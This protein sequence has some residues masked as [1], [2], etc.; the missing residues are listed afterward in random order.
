[1]ELAGGAELQ[2]QR[3]KGKQQ[4][5]CNKDREYWL[6][7]EYG[8]FHLVGWNSGHCK[9]TNTIS[10][11]RLPQQ[12]GEPNTNLTSAC[13]LAQRRLGHAFPPRPADT[14]DEEG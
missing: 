11:V 9:K 6:S 3:N 14:E 12:A 5:I 1:M 7:H 2:Q 4:D 10:R 13:D 8:S